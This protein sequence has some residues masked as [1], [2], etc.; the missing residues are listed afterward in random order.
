MTANPGSV[1]EKEK[2]CIQKRGFY[3][4][5]VTLKRCRL[6]SLYSEFIILR[7]L[8]LLRRNTSEA[9]FIAYF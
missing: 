4:S 1:K 2:I 8:Q 9:Y 7:G 6:V 3:E 5:Q